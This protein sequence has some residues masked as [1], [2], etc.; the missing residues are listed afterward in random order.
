MTVHSLD[1]LLS[2]STASK[3]PS[4]MSQQFQF[5]FSSE[6][7]TSSHGHFLF[8][9]WIPSGFMTW[10]YDAVF[11]N[12]GCLAIN[13]LS[14][15]TVVDLPVDP[16]KFSTCLCCQ[17]QQCCSPH[18]CHSLLPTNSELASVSWQKSR[19]LEEKPR[20]EIIYFSQVLLGRCSYISNTLGV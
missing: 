2:P 5:C 8:S 9:G 1:L 4:Q 10:A 17:G 6:L 18:P 14:L 13:T 19:I 16:L 20:P 7:A 3:S 11:G 15:Q 12:Y